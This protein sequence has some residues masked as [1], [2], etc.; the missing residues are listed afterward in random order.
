M[1]KK[2]LLLAAILLAAALCV[3]AW[4]YGY[5]H[6]KSND[7]L[8]ALTAIS[9]MSE[10]EV[11]SLLP[12]YRIGQLKEVWGEPDS[13]EDNTARW[14]IGGMTLTVNSKNNGRVVICGLKDAGGAPVGEAP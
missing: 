10:A 5:H 3:G 2:L 12:G 11:N 8:P 7:N 4:L 1:K 6:R 14:Q 13:A 9:A